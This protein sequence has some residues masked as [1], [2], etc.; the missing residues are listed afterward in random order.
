MPAIEHNLE[1]SMPVLRRI[2][3]TGAAAIALSFSAAALGWSLNWGSGELVKGD[4]KAAREKRE[5]TGFDGI[6]LSGDIE[7]K[8]RQNGSSRIEIEGD[9]NLLPYVET[10]VVDSRSGKSLEIGIKRGYA[11]HARQP[12]RVEVDMPSL[13][14]LGIAGSGKAEIE[15]FKSDQLDFS[16]AG[17][18]TVV[19]P[20]IDAKQVKLSIAG[21][22]D[23]LAVGKSAALT[24]SIS[25]SGDVKSAELASDEVSVTIAGSGNAQVQAIKKLKVNIAGSGD[26]RY[27]GS[28]E[29]TKSV[30]GSGSIA[31][32]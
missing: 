3:F 27:A 16:V 8:V 5:L 19:A 24:V 32:L 2:L 28:P 15:A 13:R 17:S 6:S 14:A 10:R 1:I 20:R 25:G 22:G 23:I 29:I 9:A 30:A 7:L 31:K 26:V 21:S 18:G 11:I 4:G 12:L